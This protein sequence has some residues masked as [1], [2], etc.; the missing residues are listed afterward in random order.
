[1]R[2]IKITSDGTPFGTRVVDANSGVPIDNVTK[3]V[4]SIDVNGI[5]EA[6]LTIDNVEV[7]VVGTEP[8][9]TG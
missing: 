9:E 8:G 5:A 1:M 6:V 2:K 4:W 3:I 7:A